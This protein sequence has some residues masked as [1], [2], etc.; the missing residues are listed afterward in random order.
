[1]RGK[2]APA[3]IPASKRRQNCSRRTVAGHARALG[4]ILAALLLPWAAAG[5]DSP[6]NPESRLQA[7]VAALQSGN[8]NQA[9][10]LLRS[11]LQQHPRNAHA[12]K[13]LGV[14]HAAQGQHDLASEPFLKAC[15]INPKEP[16]SCY[17]LA[18]NHYLRNRFEEALNLFDRLLRSANQDW[19]YLN[20][21][22]L[23]LHAMGRYPEAEAAFQ[24]AIARE[25]G[26]A[27]LDEKPA[28]N[29]G[30]LHLRA[31]QPEKALRILRE[32]TEAHPRAARAWFE[33]G[34]AELHL[35]QL[36]AAIA[37]L[38]RAVES[39]TRYPEA[40]LLLAKIYARQGDADKAMLHRRL[41]T[42]R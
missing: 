14:V 42:A 2:T 17:Y 15:E 31:G 21:R 19:R 30:S 6:A 41:G 8:F 13:V 9:E 40:H 24:Q 23:A 4:W 1:M 20:G 27:N 5:Q 39:R 32:V 10:S 29:L 25:G 11:L 22:G 36:D 34:K 33:Q 18:R 7:A 37:S 28:I 35:D 38:Q 3:S 12:W 16:D 26:A